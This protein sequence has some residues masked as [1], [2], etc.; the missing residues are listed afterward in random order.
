MATTVAID[1]QSDNDLKMSCIKQRSKQK[2]G[3]AW[4]GVV[5]A[6]GC[7]EWAEPARSNQRQP[8]SCCSP[9]FAPARDAVL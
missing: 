2:S 7:P 3:E 1:Q 8:R 9:L 6:R 5:L 4:H